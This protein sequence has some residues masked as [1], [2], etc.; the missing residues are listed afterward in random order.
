MEWSQPMM[1]EGFCVGAVFEEELCDIKMT[2]SR[3][4]M[5]RSQVVIESLRIH[6]QRANGQ[7]LYNVT[8]ATKR[9][10]V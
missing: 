3:C 1:V 9:S 10:I 8:E 7:D 6:I 4:Q 5:Q 2:L